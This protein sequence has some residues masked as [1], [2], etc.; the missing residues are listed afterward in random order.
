[1]CLAS[2]FATVDMLPSST[3][4]QALTQRVDSVTQ[5]DV[6]LLV[7][8]GGLRQWSAPDVAGELRIGADWAEQHL[9]MLTKRG[10][11]D[12][13]QAQYVPRRNPDLVPAVEELAR[14][15][16]THPVS[17]ITAIYKSEKRL[18]DFAEAFRIRKPPAPRKE[19][20]HG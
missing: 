9:E 3:L 2:L 15:Y 8:A 6:L 13:D 4:V 11:L 17:V 7:Y 1:M 18:E 5:L 16:R 12:R 10:L 20:D 14:L 19:P